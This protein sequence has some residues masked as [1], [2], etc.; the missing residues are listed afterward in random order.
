MVSSIP[1]TAKCTNTVHE[2]AET[3]DAGKSFVLAHFSDPHF[4]RVD[5]V[6]KGD[7]LGK[8]L[9]GYLRYKLKR[10]AEHSDELL[11]ILSKDLQRTKPDHIA[12]TGDLTQLSL[13]VEF[14]AAREWMRSL[15][16]ASRITVIPGNH[17]AYIKMDWDKTFAYWMDYMAGDVRKQTTESITSLGSLFPTL[18]IRD[19]IALIGINTAFPSGLHLATGT[20]GDDQLT[21]L[22][23]I[24]KYLSDR[25]LFR[26]I[27]IH[28]PPIPDI[29]SSRKSLTDAESLRSILERYKVELLLFG[30]THET[31]HTSLTTLSG[32]IPAI[33]APSI[34]SRSPKNERRSRYYLY[35]ITST[36]DE[37]KVQMNERFFSLEQ[38]RFIDGGQK[39][40]SLPAYRS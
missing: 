31:V 5:L 20:I 16:T 14:K 4:A 3:S 11:T 35:K 23:K 8:R 26:I 25:P 28:H 6:D 40:F 30:H 21:K 2:M 24:L 39:D 10:R 15:G 32:K 12:I 29:V 13:P 38:H 37:W 1:D 17:D 7:L 36:T 22:E 34:S 9:F 27:L 18:R 19:Q 33:G